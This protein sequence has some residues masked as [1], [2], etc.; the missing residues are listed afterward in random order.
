MIG[1]APS[2]LYGPMTDLDRME[3][4]LDRVRA[5]HEARSP[6]VFYKRDN[7]PAWIDVTLRPHVEESGAISFYVATMRD[8][9]A[10]KE[11]EAA[12]AAE[13]RKLQVTLAAIGDGVITTVADGR[14]EFVNAAAR[15]M[16]NIDQSNAYGESVNTIVRLVDGE[17]APIDLLTSGESDGEVRRGQALFGAPKSQMHVAYVTSAIGT[18][19]DGYVIVLRDV[20]AQQRLATQLTYEAS[21]DALTGLFNRRKFEDILE[22]AVATA[23][24]DGAYHTLAY[25]D[26]DRFKIVNDRCGHAVGDKVLTD[27]AHILHDR[28][29]GRD[30]IA[31]LGGDEF[32]VLL[33]DCTLAN[34][35]KVLEKLR[36][37]VD[38]YALVHNGETFTVGVSIGLAPIEG[39]NADGDAALSAADAACYAA[40]AAGRNVIVG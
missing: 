27:I 24:S 3:F 40:K 11:F 2:A 12:L 1:Q 23:R 38:E 37:G 35:R 10:R 19:R 34:A 20:T 18:H 14:I 6:V 15:A 17:G 8:V 29:R 39:P 33:H 9:T 13:K 22:R 36:I 25:L 30:V 16:L 28:L 31:R 26:L 4:L 32:A 7:L 21:H 5:G